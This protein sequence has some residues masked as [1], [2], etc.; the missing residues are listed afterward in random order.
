MKRAG[1]CV[2]KKA[3]PYTY[4][5]IEVAKQQYIN[6][7]AVLGYYECPTCLDFHLTSK[8]CNL[9]HLH[10]EWQR[11]KD[12]K[13]TYGKG[14]KRTH[15]NQDR[16]KRAKARKLLGIPAPLPPLKKEKPKTIWQGDISIKIRE[17][18]KQHSLLHRILNAIIK[19]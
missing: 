1:K 16:K 4:L 8:Y 14:S 9:R 12:W 18:K 17:Y 5:A 11:V 19:R 6:H 2:N 13:S 3:Y 10:K 7:G 15:K